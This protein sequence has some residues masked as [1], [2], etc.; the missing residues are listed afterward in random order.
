MIELPEAITL[1]SQL[2]ARITGRV[3]KEVVVGQSP[4][5]FAFFAEPERYG[6]LLE[7]KAIEGARSSGA[8]VEILIEGN[9]S[10]LINDGVRLSLHTDQL[11]IPKKHQ[12]LI[13][14]SDGYLISATVQAYG[15]LYCQERANIDNKYFLISKAKPSPLT[16]DF[17]D[18]YFAK[19]T[20]ESKANLSTK[21]F[22]ATEQRIPG[23]GN[24]VLQDILFTAKINP[25][26]KLAKLPKE[27]QEVL[28]HSLKEILGQMTEQGGRDTERDLF[29]N[30]GGYQTLM[31]KNT[32]GSKCPV[33]KTNIVK[34]SYL[35]G[36]VYFCPQCQ[37]LL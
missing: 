14:F 2:Q 24:G 11:S 4:H 35:G 32:V 33:C 34:E 18:A 28:F 5:K 15:M 16:D 20:S 1:A 26:T 12:L 23:V 9:V 29:G 13:E 17:S 22:L 30:P 10:I 25:K 27:Q 36:S 7:G 19:L 21:A 6:T 37:P 3:V 31:S 8:F